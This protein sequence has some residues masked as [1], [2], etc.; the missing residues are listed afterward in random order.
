VL[1]AKYIKGP[2]LARERQ[3][4]PDSPFAKLAKLKEHLEAGTKEPH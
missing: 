4:D 3:P 2:G 1:R